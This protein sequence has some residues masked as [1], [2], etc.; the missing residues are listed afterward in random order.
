MIQLKN[1]VEEIRIPDLKIRGIWNNLLNWISHIR[2][3]YR[4]LSFLAFLVLLSIFM[5]TYIWLAFFNA[6]K[7]NAP[8]V[9]M[10]IIFSLLAISLVWKTGQKIDVWAFTYL[11]MHGRRAPWLDWLMLAFTQLGNFVFA[12]LVAL[13]IYFFESHLVAY[14]LIFGLLTLGL[15]VGIMKTLIRRTR[16]YAELKNIR[17]V[18]S[19]ASG[20]SFPSGHTAQA[21]FM[22]T[23]LLHYFQINPYVWLT[24]YSI[25]LLVGITRIYV[26]MHYPRDVLA[27]AI[28]GTLW[29]TIGVIVNS[30]LA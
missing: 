4:V 23:L 8:L 24:L 1:K 13:L 27:G 21:F 17:I 7:S 6:I 2:H 20:R 11:N 12:L 3:I 28:I 26:G 9:C 10:V 25:A 14:E 22:A 18:G 16:P 30:Y 19:R 15:V 5:P 29:G